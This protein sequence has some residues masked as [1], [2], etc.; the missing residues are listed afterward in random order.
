MVSQSQLN[1]FLYTI[2]CTHG[3]SSQSQNTKVETKRDYCFLECY[4]LWAPLWLSPSNGEVTAGE[5]LKLEMDH[6]E[7]VFHCC[8]SPTSAILLLL[9]EVIK[10]SYP[11]P[12][13]SA[14]PA[15]HSPNKESLAVPDPTLPSGHPVIAPSLALWPSLS[16]SGQVFQKGWG[17]IQRTLTMPKW[18]LF[19]MHA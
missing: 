12:W 16:L 5:V 10:S 3:V 8:L 17:K 13:W 7:Y 15:G 6:R 1:A 4:F 2:C 9:Y 18:D 14:S 11:G 19:Q